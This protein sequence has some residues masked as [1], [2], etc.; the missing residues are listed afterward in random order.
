LEIAKAACGTSNQ[1]GPEQFQPRWMLQQPTAG[2]VFS[3]TAQP[4]SQ[5]TVTAMAAKKRNVNQLPPAAVTKIAAMS[6]A[7]IATFKRSSIQS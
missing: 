3:S 7:L 6:T 2:G 1:L 4:N 5:V